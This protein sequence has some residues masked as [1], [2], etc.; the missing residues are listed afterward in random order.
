LRS[1]LRPRQCATRRRHQSR[2][3]IFRTARLE[4]RQQTPK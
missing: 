1:R 2:S 3:L 4:D